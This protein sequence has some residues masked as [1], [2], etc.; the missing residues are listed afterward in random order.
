MLRKIV[1]FSKM[2]HFEFQVRFVTYHV[3]KKQNKNKLLINS[4]LLRIKAQEQT[5]D[6]VIIVFNIHH[7]KNIHTIHTHTFSSST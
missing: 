4:G 2:Y 3:K 7:F 5:N 1:I 6:P